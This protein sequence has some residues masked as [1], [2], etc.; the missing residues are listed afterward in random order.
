MFKED[1]KD[2]FLFLDEDELFY[3]FSA[4]FFFILGKEPCKGVADNELSDWVLKWILTGE[5]KYYNKLRDWFVEQI[6]YQIKKKRE[7][8]ELFV[9]QKPEVK[10]GFVYIIKVNDFY[11]IG[12]ATNI[13][14]RMKRYIT[15]NPYET[16]LIF[17]KEVDDY[18]KVEE[19]LLEKFK[20]KR[21]RSEW[22]KLTEDDIKWVKQNV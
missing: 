20:D 16:E 18:V 5:K 3:Y 21:V 8:E 10:R 22:F 17:K 4:G 2:V 12:R 11:K 6:K 13:N 15:E 9:E 14:G 19:F 1:I 7:K